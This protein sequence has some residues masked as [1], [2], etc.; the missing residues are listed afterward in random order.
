MHGFFAI[1]GYLICQSYVRSPTLI[2]FT[3]NRVLRIGPGLVIAMIITKF[4]ADFC[5]GFKENPVPY[6]ANGP[7]WTLTWEVVC[8]FGLAILG[9]LKG[10]STNSIPAFFAA[11][12]LMY[13]TNI[14]STNDTYLVI[15]PMAMMFLSGTFVAV[16][17]NSAAPR[18]FPLWTAIG[19]A[20]ITKLEIFQ[21]LYGWTVSHIP[22]LWGPAINIEQ[23]MRIVYMSTF[24]FLLIYVGKSAK[25]VI[26]ITNDIS[27]GVYI[28]G[29]PIAQAIAF[30][31]IQQKENLSPL[32]YFGLTMLFTLPVAFA[33]WKLIEKPSLS[34]KRLVGR[35]KIIESSSTKRPL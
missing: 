28:Y 34:L 21:S 8:Y 3:L 17:D 14:S 11:A 23:A 19:L 35:N 1:S 32:V 6:I 26:K 4:I 25:P 15:A 31:T 16:M 5:G 12:W 18:T 10:L 30:I 7:V 20:T 22:F 9:L 27:Y 33:S 2:S 24:P 13:L 29:W